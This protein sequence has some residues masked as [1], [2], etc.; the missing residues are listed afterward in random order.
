MLVSI[1]QATELGPG[2]GASSK[3]G[4]LGP[5]VKVSSKLKLS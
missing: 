4:L 1:L 3:L 2:N 5:P